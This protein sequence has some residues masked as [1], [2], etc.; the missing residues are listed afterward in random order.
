MS[1]VSFLPMTFIRHSRKRNERISIAICAAVAAILVQ[2]SLAIQGIDNLEGEAGFRM[3]S[4][5]WMYPPEGPSQRSPI[6]FQVKFCEL[7]SWG[8][9]RCRYQ[10]VDEVTARSG[11]QETNE[12]KSPGHY[13]ADIGGLRM[14]TN[15][16]FQVIPLETET[17]ESSPSRISLQ[18]K[19]FSAKAKNCLSDSSEV[20]VET[21]PYFGGRISVEDSTIPGCF[22]KGNQQSAQTKYSLSIRHKDCGS[23]VN[24]SKVTTVILVQEN[25]PILTH[26][27]RRFVVV[28]SFS[29]ESFV[30]KAGVSLPRETSV[31]KSLDFSRL[32]RIS[33]QSS[34][35]LNTDSDTG[36]STNQQQ[37][38]KFEDGLPI[39]Q[40]NSLTQSNPL[41]NA[42]ESRAFSDSLHRGTW[43]TFL[44]FGMICV[45]IIA[46]MSSV[47]WFVRSYRSS[48]NPADS[49]RIRRNHRG[50]VESLDG[51][52]GYSYEDSYCSSSNSNHNSL[53]TRSDL[54]VELDFEFSEDVNRPENNSN[55]APVST[56]SHQTLQQQPLQHHSYA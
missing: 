13:L 27:T 26:S 9:N 14:A 22:I 20:I 24:G 42:A 17:S 54:E 48:G 52:S 53:D 11:R 39:S 55:T 23:H 37:D 25:V 51:S 19:G 46:S 7:H 29:P 2:L 21:G 45:A 41:S 44:V 35:L 5:K 31:A 18:T 8:L 15:Y 38:F 12:A 30:V 36:S 4:L 33:P 40:Y 47:I 28:C 16:T 34:N 1:L 3:V 50:D 49:E 56:I 10:I 43:E 6:S 32:I